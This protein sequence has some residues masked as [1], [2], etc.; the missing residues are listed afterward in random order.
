MPLSDK[1]RGREEEAKGHMRQ[2]R[3][4]EES[5]RKREGDD[6]TA[7]HETGKLDEG[8]ER[9]TTK[10][11]KMRQARLMKRKRERGREMAVRLEE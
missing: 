2:A 5:V 7:G 3:M 1:A 4:D 11:E 9:E 8:S 10:Q 6:K